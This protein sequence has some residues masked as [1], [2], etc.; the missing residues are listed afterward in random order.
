MNDHLE[1]MQGF[2]DIG[3]RFFL[4]GDALKIS[5]PIDYELA[6]RD[7]LWLAEIK[8]SVIQFVKDGLSIGG[9]QC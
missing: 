1:L 2:E 8:P 7:R 5:V 9:N 6:D 3:F 4:F